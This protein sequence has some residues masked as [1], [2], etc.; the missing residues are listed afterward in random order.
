MVKCNWCDESFQ[1]DEIIFDEQTE[2][3]FCPYCQE[4]G[5]LMDT[6]TE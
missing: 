5:C 4:S 6:E 3:E 2:K 1:E